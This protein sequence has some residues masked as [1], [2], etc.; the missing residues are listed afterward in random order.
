MS[1]AVAVRKMRATHHPDCLHIV[2][3]KREETLSTDGKMSLAVTEFG[4][5]IGFWSPEPAPEAGL[6]GGQ[7]GIGTSVE[8]RIVVDAR[9]SEIESKEQDA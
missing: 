6:T 8:R 9:L 1:Q 3:S 4:L 5:L 2:K 7:T